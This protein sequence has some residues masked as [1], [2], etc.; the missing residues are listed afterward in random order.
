VGT[1]VQ[2][3]IAA[4]DLGQVGQLATGLI[5]LPE[6]PAEPFSVKTRLRIDKAGY[7]IED[8]RATLANAVA[9]VDGRI[10]RT[11]GFFGTD[12]TIDSDGPNASLFTAVTGV[13]IPVAPF[14][15]R[16]RFQRTDRGFHFDQ[17]SVQ[18]GDYRAYANGSLGEAPRWVGT[19]LE[20][21]ASGPGLAL[22]R[23]L[24]GVHALP[25]EEFRIAG[26]FKGT[27]ELFTADGL[28]FVVGD[29]DLRGSIDVDIRGKPAVTARMSSNKLN[30]APYL[31]HLKGGSDGDAEQAAASETPKDGLVFSNEPLDFSPLRRADAEVDVTI[32]TLQLPAKVFRDVTI[33]ARLADGR[34]E[35][36]RFEMVGQREGRGSGTLV[37]EPVG[38]DYRVDMVLDLEAL[39][40]DLP[41][42]D[43]VDPASEP[44]IDLDVRLE[45]LGSSPHAFAGSA[46]GL[47]QVV[48]GRGVMD[49]EALDLVSADILLTLLS[50]FN[51]FA[52]EDAV[53]ELQCGVALLSIEDGLASLEPMA[54]QSDKMTMLGKGKIDLGTEKID[55]QWVTKPRKGIGLSASM[56]TNPYIKLGGTLSNPS[57]QLKGAEAVASTG[58]AVATLGLSLVAKGMLDRITA[59]KKVCKQ[60]LE[61]IG[62]KPDSPTRK[63]NKKGKKN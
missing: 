14:K 58:V 54:L 4:P 42:E 37:L 35:V 56:I 28:D 31:P 57:V 25:D 23:E 11:P 32:G 6:L 59:E 43:T 20:L 29:S 27:P 33:G 10:G 24:T 12:L 49:N 47:V 61:E 9:A 45:M 39:R 51:P 2:I 21:R 55:L 53:T 50:A 19:D 52:K 3:D 16:G 5:P 34:L 15:L 60:A 46:N 40:L 63:A 13:T 36:H 41:D 7:E 48:I 1:D 18:L 62:R 17:F 44:P 38:N 30:L 22:F 26:R 8:L